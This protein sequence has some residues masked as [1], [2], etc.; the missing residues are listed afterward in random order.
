MASISNGKD[1]YIYAEE[2]DTMTWIQGGGLST[3]GSAWFVGTN[4]RLIYATRG[5]S[6][7]T[8]VMQSY[9]LT[10]AGI[11]NYSQM[12]V[13]KTLEDR[14]AALELLLKEREEKDGS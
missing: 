13:N 2:S 7:T 14:I 11:S 12:N 3:Y 6:N 4:G 10:G 9:Q 8:E 5:G 1:L